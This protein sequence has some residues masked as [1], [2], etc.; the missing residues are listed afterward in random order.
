MAI[1]PNFNQ[2][3]DSFG[4]GTTSVR[5]GVSALEAA[6]NQQQLDHASFIHAMYISGAL[7]LVALIV[8][9]FLFY[10]LKKARTVI[11]G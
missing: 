9:L 3:L 5:P 10:R 8:I 2:Y 7:L 11:E 4:T 1:I 6:Q